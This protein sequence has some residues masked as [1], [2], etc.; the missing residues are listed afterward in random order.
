MLYPSMHP[1][2]GSTVSFDHQGY[3]RLLR[4]RARLWH[5]QVG[6]RVDPTQQVLSSGLHILVR[7]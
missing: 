6:G 7:I 4:A 1:I 5:F 3:G 2:C